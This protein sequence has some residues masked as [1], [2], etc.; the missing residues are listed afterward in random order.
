MKGFGKQK[1]G[2]ISGRQSNKNKIL[3]L[4]ATMDEIES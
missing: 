2:S 3:S 1:N 4:M